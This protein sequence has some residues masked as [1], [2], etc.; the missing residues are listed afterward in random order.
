MPAIATPPEITPAS[1]ATSMRSWHRVGRILEVLVVVGPGLM[2][3]GLATGTFV[4]ERIPEITAPATTKA[5]FATMLIVAMAT[6]LIRRRWPTICLAVT[7]VA[8]L[9]V[10][11][12]QFPFNPVNLYVTLA[13]SHF[14]VV[15]PRRRTVT[16][17]LVIAAIY[18]L[19]GIVTWTP[20]RPGAALDGALWVLAGTAVGSAMRSQREMVR[21]L[22]ERAERAESAREELVL[23]GVAEDRVRVA[24][25]LHD[26]IA[27]HVSAIGVQTGS[28]AH[29]LDSRPDLAKK[30]LGEARASAAKVLEELQLV[31][32]VLRQGESLVP[33]S[34]IPGRPDVNELLASAATADATLTTAGIEHLDALPAESFMVAFRLLQ[35]SLTNAHRHAPGAAV[36]IRIQPTE[37]ATVIEVTNARPAQPPPPVEPE[38]RRFGLIGMQER[39]DSVGGQLTTG[40]TLSGGYRVWAEL[41][42]SAPATGDIGKEIR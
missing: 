16:V 18:L 15:H 42:R 12:M 20:D 17:A 40:P 30:L 5:L 4:G 2:M 19:T 8:G 29:V 25:E 41:P 38:R 1:A 33:T 23:R 26:I 35:E 9:T 13:M 39:V 14:A 31:L 34:V 21:A 3:L 7:L 10:E 36:T 6:T 24:R 22:E 37:A 11:F 28:A 32:G 27:H